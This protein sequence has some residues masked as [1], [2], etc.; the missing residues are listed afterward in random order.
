MR[1]GHN[2]QGERAS[3]FIPFCSVPD[4]GLLNVDPDPVPAPDPIK[5]GGIKL[6]NNLVHLK[7]G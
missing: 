1:R 3:V 4:P 2:G 6:T 7:K 5:I